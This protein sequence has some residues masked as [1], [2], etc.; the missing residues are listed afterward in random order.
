MLSFKVFNVFLMFVKGFLVNSVTCFC[1]MFSLM[2]IY[3]YLALNI[4]FFRLKKYN[5]SCKII[6]SIWI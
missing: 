5:L 6:I 2:K 4:L 3:V 1:R